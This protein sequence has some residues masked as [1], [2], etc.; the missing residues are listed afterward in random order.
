MSFFEKPLSALYS[1]AK[2]GAESLIVWFRKKYNLSPKDPRFLDVTYEEIQEDWLVEQLAENPH[3]TLAELTVNRA[4]DEEWM[5]KMEQ[6]EIESHLKEI[7]SKPKSDFEVLER[8][9]R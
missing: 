2:E 8:E 7:F 1:K 4:A 9:T 5:N 6:E 3:L